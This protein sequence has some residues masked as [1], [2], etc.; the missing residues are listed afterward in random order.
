MNNGEFKT[1]QLAI[2]PYLL[3]NGLK[4][5]RAEVAM[6][7]YDRPVV[8]FVFKDQYG[9]GRDLEIDFVKSDF[10]KYRDMTFFFRNEIEKLTRTVD[11]INLKEK[12]KDDDKYI[13]DISV[14]KEG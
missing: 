2:C 7:K 10:K 3:L 4:Y 1:D 6:G 14:S 8:V 13:D 9:V 12:R 5:L 11:K